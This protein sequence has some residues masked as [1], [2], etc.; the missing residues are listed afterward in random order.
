[1]MPSDSKW[2]VSR[3][4]TEA[5]RG[6]HSFEVVG[7]SLKK[8]IGVG[9]F[10]R[11]GVFSVGGYD[12]EIRFYPD[13]ASERTKDHYASVY[14]NLVT[15]GAEVRALYGLRLRNQLH[16][17]PDFVSSETTPRLFNSSQDSAFAP[18]T[19]KF[20]ARSTLELGYAG[21]VVDDCLTIECTVT[22]IEH[23]PQ[24]SKTMGGFSI[25]VPPSEL[26]ENLGTLL[27]EEE[28]ADI[29]FVVEGATFH[30]HKIVLAMRSPVFKAELYGQ[31]KERTE[32]VVA[33]ED[34]QPLVFKALLNF[35]YT[36]LVPEWDDLNDD[37][38]GEMV[39]HLLVA[40][41]RYAI[42]RL[43]LM[44]A[45]LLVDHLDVDNVAT[46]LA[47]ADQHDCQSLK[48]V[49]IEFMAS[50]DELDAVVETQGYEHLKRTC[51]SVLVDVLERTTKI[52][53]TI[54]ISTSS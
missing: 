31:M 24:V 42:D 28:T 4:T 13:G 52:R 21:Y 29:T 30:A 23:P 12:W 41:D 50:S 33:I 36:D 15:E 44:C 20:I 53:K 9:N 7:Y 25:E 54:Q 26:A 38:Y 51:P 27:T 3:C 46:T 39:R 35:I 22:V 6:T 11:S 17:Q 40:A 5:A 43:K 16:G 47:L 19:S 48:D 1:M 37:E 10:I 14:L 8:G 45:S 49:C 18:L 34:M 32:Q 2:T